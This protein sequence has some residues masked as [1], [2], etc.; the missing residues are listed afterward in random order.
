MYE[1][2][3]EV[4]YE[5]GDEVMY[6]ECDEVMYEEGDEVMYEEGDEVMYE[7]GDEVMYEEGDEVMYEEGDEVMY[8]EGDEVMYEEGDDVMYEEGDEVMY[9]EG[10]EVMYEEGDEVMYEEG[11]EVMY[12]EGDKVM[13]EE[14]DD[15]MYEEGDDVMYEECDEVMYEEG[16]EVMYEEGDEVMYEEGDEVMYE[17]GDEV[18]EKERKRGT[19]FVRG[20]DSQGVLLHE[21]LAALEEDDEEEIPSSAAVSSPDEAPGVD[22]DEDSDNS[23]GEAQY[24]D[25]IEFYVDNTDPSTSTERLPATMVVSPVLPPPKCKRF[26]EAVKSLPQE[27]LFSSK[28]LEQ[29]IQIRPNAEHFLCHHIKCP[30]DAFTYFSTH[31][32]L[33]LIIEETNRYAG[34]HLVH[35]L[36]V[37]SNEILTVICIMLLSGYHSLPH[38]RMY[39]QTQPDIH[40]SIVAEAMRRSSFDEIVRYLHIAD[41]AAMDGTDHMYKVHPLFYHFNS[42]FKKISVGHS[43]S[44]DESIPYFGHHS[45]KQF[46]KGKPIRFG[47]KLWVAAD[48]SGYIFHVEPYCGTSTRFPITGNGIVTV[49][50]NCDEVE[51]KKNPSLYSRTEKKTGLVEVPSP[52]AKYNANMCGVDLCDQF[53]STYLCGIRSKKCL[54]CSWLMTP[55]TRNFATTTSSHSEGP[56]TTGHLHPEAPEDVACFYHPSSDNPSALPC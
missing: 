30:V 41:S 48:P 34:E 1:E 50:T 21:I 33:S 25:G 19:E 20:R 45:A 36:N 3:D 9:E 53:V 55:E 47:F 32:L 46:I 11:D 18:M 26:P 43:V 35:N 6:E 7:E 5:E 49:L 22:S 42:A 28:L 39:W 29:D 56:A 51:P 52:I 16:D 37:S 12:E 8:E 54:L 23:D 4:M 13:Y 31:D 27:M 44:I 14:G 40:V 2:G 38:K 17:E 15:V 10:D 24:K